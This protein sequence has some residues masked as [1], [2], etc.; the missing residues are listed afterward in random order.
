[1][2]HAQ[3]AA[4][5]QSLNGQV[6]TPPGMADEVQARLTHNL[7]S[8]RTQHLESIIWLGRRT[9]YLWRYHEAIDIFS[10]GLEQYPNEPHLLRH[11]GH[12]YLSVREFYRAIADLKQAAAQIEGQ[13]MELLENHAYY[14]LLLAFKGDGDLESLLQNPE[15]LDNATQGYGVGNWYLWNGDEEKARAVFEKVLTGSYWA[16]FGYIAAEAE[17]QRLQ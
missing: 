1:M 16:A 8:A 15:A 14:W 5:V 3:E 10:Q 2:M 4:P 6:L 13:E 17:L 9:A 11:R 12:R 7:D